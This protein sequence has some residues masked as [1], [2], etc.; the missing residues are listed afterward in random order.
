MRLALI[1]TS[2]ATLVFGSVESRAYVGAYEGPW[3][4]VA[5]IGGGN[6]TWDCHYQS[7]EECAPNVI[8]GNRGFCNR[9]PRW[10]GYYQNGGWAPQHRKQEPWY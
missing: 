7:F 10:P 6:V 5:P 1:A 8:S 2:V 9:N 4:A 3:C